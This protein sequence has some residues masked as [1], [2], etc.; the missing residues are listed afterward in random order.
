MSIDN[1]MSSS[2][3]KLLAELKELVDSFPDHQR[4][5][6][7]KAVK[8]VISEVTAH[9]CGCTAVKGIADK[10]SASETP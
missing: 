1:V 6:V 8:T 5:E 2:G 10:Q 9:S 4:K 3:V 7:L